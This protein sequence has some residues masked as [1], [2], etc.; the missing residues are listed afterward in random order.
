M[1]DGLNEIVI[2][3]PEQGEE[4]EVLLN[5]AADALLARR[6]PRFYRVFGE[7]HSLRA[8]DPSAA[9]AEAPDTRV[10]NSEHTITAS[11]QATELLATN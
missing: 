10:A 11:G 8:F 9:A 2:S 6:M 1:T 4:S 3:W 5:R 7:I